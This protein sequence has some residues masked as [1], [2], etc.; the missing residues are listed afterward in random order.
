MFLCGLSRKNALRYSLSPTLQ[1]LLLLDL[2]F[3]FVRLARR[4]NHDKK[5]RYPPFSF[6]LNET[7]HQK[8][9]PARVS[10]SAP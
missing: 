3:L 8:L 4:H 1:F 5:V 7:S 10:F 6:T 2:N 9:P